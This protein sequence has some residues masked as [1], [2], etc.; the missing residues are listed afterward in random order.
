MLS[1]TGRNNRV[2]QSNRYRSLKI[3]FKQIIN[4][5]VHH[6]SLC[7]VGIFSWHCNE[8]ETQRAAKTRGFRKHVCSNREWVSLSRQE[9]PLALIFLRVR[10]LLGDYYFFI[11][12]FYVMFILFLF[13][14]HELFLEEIIHSYHWYQIF[15]SITQIFKQISLTHSLDHYHSKLEKTSV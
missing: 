14:H 6:M 4:L 7:L 1:G 11:N 13:N 10:G 5:W 8:Q 12:L 9:T 15:L 2:F 3:H